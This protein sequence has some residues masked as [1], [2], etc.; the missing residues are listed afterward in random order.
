VRNP[1][2][3]LGRPATERHSTTNTTTTTMSTPSK[4][5]VNRCT[6][7]ETVEVCIFQREIDAREAYAALVRMS[8]ANRD[9]WYEVC[10][11]IA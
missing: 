2:V 10:E 6:D 1:L 11:I 9:Y 3:S 4:F 8:S 7:Y 5:I